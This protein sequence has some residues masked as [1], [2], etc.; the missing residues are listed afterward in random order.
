MIKK[1]THIQDTLNLLGALPTLN[2]PVPEYLYIATEN[3]RCSKVDIYIKEG[4]YVKCGQKIGERHAA[5]FDQ[6]I[7]ATCSGTFVGYEKHYH[8]SG[9]LVN[10][11]KFHNDYK[12]T[13]DE[14]IH[15]R[16]DEEIAKLTKDDMTEILKECASVGLGGS[17]FPT[18]IKFQTKEK[19]N[20]ILI[21]AIECEPYI[22][23]DHRAA[24]E[25][26]EKIIEGIKFIQQAFNCYDA[27]ICIK[28]KYHDLEMIYKDMLRRYPNSG[29]TLC[30]VGNYYPQGWEINM[31]KEATGIEVATGTLPSKY[32]IIDFNLSTV[33][34]I[35]QNIRENKAVL[36]RHMTV[37]GNGI[38]YPSN[39]NVRIGTPVSELIERCGGYK[40][41]EKKKV[42]I[43]GGPMMGASLP[44]DDCI[45]T[46]TVTS[47]IVLDEMEYKEEP[48]IRC[49][50]C[51]LSCPVHLKPVEIMNTMRSMP[52]NKEKIK[53][54][55]P[56]KCI[57]CGLCTYS[58][59]SK[60]PV[61]DYIR[62]AKVIARLK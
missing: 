11:M 6:P 32:G 44:S 4:D 27:R 43:L 20:T 14:S 40:N 3:A 51:V 50:S 25:E 26:P 37:T 13:M 42:F 7:Q 24:I 23:A 47:V 49:G 54:L 2:A 9:K 61:T 52:V 62:R 22:N 41:P 8:R 39:F 53:F 5:F 15:T 56:L 21:N 19:I 16:S 29:I 17:S 59:T 12:D 10:F 30:K 34:G 35:Q 28:S 36:E 18:Y 45:C 33:L 57:E 48:C 38:N 60:I 31:I 46:K 58:C 55:N 1:T